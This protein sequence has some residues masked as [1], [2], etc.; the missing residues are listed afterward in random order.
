MGQSPRRLVPCDGSPRPRSRVRGAAS[1]CNPAG[2]GHV[3]QRN[4]ARR[5]P[6]ARSPPAPG[7]TDCAA[8][9]GPRARRRSACRRPVAL[10]GGDV[11]QP[12]DD[13]GRLDAVAA[14]EHRDAQ[15]GCHF[16]HQ[17]PIGDAGVR[18]L[19]RSTMDGDGRRPGI[20]HHAARGPAHS[21]MS[22]SSRRASSPSPESARPWSS[23]RSRW[24][25]ARARASGCSR[26]CASRSSERGSPC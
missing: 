26:R 10:S 5:R 7:S 9:R 20:L 22:R 16:R 6:A 2:T 25:H 4:D 15:R 12:L 21:A 1:R 11:G 14:A 19:G 3:L 8:R 18:L 24:R 17:T 13:L 23:R